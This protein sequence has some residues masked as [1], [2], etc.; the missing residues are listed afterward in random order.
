MKPL[1]RWLLVMAYTAL[2]LA[3]VITAR[4]WWQGDIA[5]MRW[6]HWLLLACLPLLAWIYLRY[7]SVFAPGKGQCLLAPDGED[8]RGQ[9][10]DSSQVEQNQTGRQVRG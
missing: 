9:G 6:Y 7:L 10:A 2:A 1:T 8:R 3:A 5:D 4:D